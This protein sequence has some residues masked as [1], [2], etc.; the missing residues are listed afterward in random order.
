MTPNPKKFGKIVR[1][2]RLEKGLSRAELAKESGIETRTICN[3]E[4]GRHQGKMIGFT[5]CK[6]LDISIDEI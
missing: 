3:V 1:S 2:K 6:I 4:L 5:L